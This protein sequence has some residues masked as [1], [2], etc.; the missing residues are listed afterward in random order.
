MRC[1]SSRK[2]WASHSADSAACLAESNSGESETDAVDPPP[3]EPLPPEPAE[4]F[5]PE[6]PATKNTNPNNRAGARDFNIF[7]IIIGLN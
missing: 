3:S 2:R 5:E 7:T 1:N 6:Q 4:G